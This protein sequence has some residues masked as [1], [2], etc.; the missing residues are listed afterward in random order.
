LSGY[1]KKLALLMAASVLGCGAIVV[2]SAQTASGEP[3]PQ[4]PTQDTVQPGSVDK[5]EEVGS[6]FAPDSNLA[7]GTGAL[8][9]R[10]MLAVL[11]VLVL[12]VGAIYAS[13]K[14][15]PRIINAPGKRIRIIETVHFGPKKAIHVIEVGNR[16]LL[17]G[18][19]AENITNLAD[20]TD[21]MIDLSAKQEGQ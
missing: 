20:I 11:F 3:T 5:A 7:G 17:L 15:L 1:R 2:H 6:F 16:R 10:T 19:T 14:L 12:G 9:F 4:K 21:D 13:K 18:S 8:F